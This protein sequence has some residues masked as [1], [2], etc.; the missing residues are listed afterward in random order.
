MASRIRDIITSDLDTKMNPRNGKY[1]K[2]LR[3]TSGNFQRTSHRPRI[4]YTPGKLII[5][6][7]ITIRRVSH[8]LTI[9]V[10]NNTPNVSSTPLK[11]TLLPGGHYLAKQQKTHL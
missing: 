8:R 7:A 4:V 11:R 10:E 2:K 6:S 9:S 5:L 1:T 3:S